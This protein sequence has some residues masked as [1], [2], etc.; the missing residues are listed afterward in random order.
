MTWLLWGVVGLWS[1]VFHLIWWSNII[2]YVQFKI[3]TDEPIQNI[4]LSNNQIRENATV[5]TIVGIL[6]AY[7]PD[8][9]RP[10]NVNFSIVDP[11]DCP[12]QL[13][14]ANNHLLVLNRTVNFEE[15][16]TLVVTIR[17]TDSAGSCL[18]WPFRINILGEFFLVSY[19][20]NWFEPRRM[21]GCLHK[22]ITLDIIWRYSSLKKFWT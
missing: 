20:S 7:D 4:T 16:P 22:L 18:Q 15:T 10:K 3:D 8:V 1:T 17:V 9:H 11:E 6:D 21:S 14:G 19:W 13:K 2:V 5:G 12:F